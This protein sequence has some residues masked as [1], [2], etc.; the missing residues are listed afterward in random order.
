MDIAVDPTSSSQSSPAASTAP[1]STFADLGGRA[2]TGVVAIPILIA[3]VAW[4]AASFL[5]VMVVAA[6]FA[7]L[8][9][10][11][12]ISAQ[13]T[14]AQRAV[15]VF[16]GTPAVVAALGAAGVLLAAALAGPTVGMAGVVLCVVLALP[17]SRLRAPA[18]AVAAVVPLAFLLWWVRDTGGPWWIALAFA[19]TW[20]GDAGAY[21]VGKRW[22]RR[23]LAPVT[24]P[25]KTIE[26][27]LG[28]L[29]VSAL[30]GAILGALVLDVDWPIAALVASGINVVGQAGDLLESKLKRARNVKDSGTSIP[31]YGGMLDKMDSLFIS[32]PVLALA[33]L[34]LS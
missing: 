31:G 2:L 13:R 11:N 19:T 30:L 29:F 23:K 1:R 20:L 28:G 9:L 26:G 18:L 16:T 10:T 14:A 33:V 4:N 7:A 8:E 24:S 22:G 12:L 34:W 32:T 15:P 17:H 5:A 25:N 3:L 21:F 6:A 27:A